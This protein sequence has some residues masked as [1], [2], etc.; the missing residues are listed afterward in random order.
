MATVRILRSTTAAATPGSLVSGQIAINEADGVL[1]YRNGSGAVTPFTSSAS[2]ADGYVYDCGAYSSVAPSAPTA[3]TGTA[4]NAQVSLSWSAP[5]L[6][7]GSAITDYTIQYSS[8]GGSSYTTFSRSA[9]TATT[10][11]VTG[12]TNSTA[13]IFRVSATSSAGTGSYSTASASLT[14]VSAGPLLTIT[15][16]SGGASTF[17][18]SGSTFTRTAGYYDDDVDG[19]TKY[20]WTATASAT[21]T[22]TFSY[23]DEYDGSGS[24]YIKKNGSTVYTVS[25]GT[26]ITRTVSVASTD[27]ITIISSKVDGNQWFFNVSISA[28]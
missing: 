8:N 13:Y 3:L 15:R 14:P 2:L 21:V 20:K 26:A 12:L 18:Q 1:F 19:L 22:V 17:T 24:A 11:T 27:E 28:A 6:T 25:Q 9:S 5:A 10:A 7:G 16:I 23:T 4:G